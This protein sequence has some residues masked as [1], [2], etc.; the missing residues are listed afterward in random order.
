[1][2]VARSPAAALPADGAT[3]AG[4]TAGPASEATAPEVTL[5][6]HQR[7]ALAALDQVV[8]GGRRRAWVVLPPGAG[9]TL[10]GLEF[11]R[12][13]GRPTVVFGPNTAIQ[14]QW[15]NQC[16]TF[17]PDA[18]SV[19]TDRSLDRPFTAL[20]Y[21]ALATFEPDDEVDEDGQSAAGEESLIDRL[22]E[23]GRALVEAMRAQPELTVVLDECH[24]LL[25]VWG[26][27]L[28]ELLAELP[29]A[30]VLGLTATP[31]HTVSQERKALVDELFGTPVYTASIPA[32]VREG[33]L[34]PFGELVW[35]TTPTPTEADWLAEESERFAELV[36]DLTDP[37]F[38][39]VPFLEWL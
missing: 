39:S 27:L 33:T 3:Q 13:V 21:Q 11:A 25:E 17:L 18:G 9:K 14:A 12:R 38:G 29:Q 24:H 37:S 30:R 26:R 15:A 5:R 32:A 8:A 28:A 35:L 22:H 34:A 36:T 19:C 6:R 7:E 1:A 23:N 4:V 20:T 16:R 31:P 10:V 2:A